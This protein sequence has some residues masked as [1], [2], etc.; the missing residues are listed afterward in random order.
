[1]TRLEAFESP[2]CLLQFRSEPIYSR[3][4]KT[5]HYSAAAAIDPPSKAHPSVGA[6]SLHV[7]S[8]VFCP[9][10]Y[11]ALAKVLL[12]IYVATAS[13]PKVLAAWLQGY[14][15]NKISQSPEAGGAVLW[16]QARVPRVRCCFQL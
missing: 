10:R 11:L 8:K 4:E 5:W 7:L 2:T 16:D 3:Y 6:L 14:R 15:D 13:P 1:M 12:D 9:E